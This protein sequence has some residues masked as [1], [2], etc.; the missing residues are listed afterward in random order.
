[1]PDS[2]KKPKKDK[3]NP[4]LEKLYDLGSALPWLSTEQKDPMPTPDPLIMIIQ[5]Q[6]VPRSPKRPDLQFPRLYISNQRKV[7]GHYRSH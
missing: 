3:P 1:M 4:K 5:E 2:K 7:G 6:S